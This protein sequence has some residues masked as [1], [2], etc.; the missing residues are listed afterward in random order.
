MD[1]E[2]NVF[3]LFNFY[4]HVWVLMSP[5]RAKIS[6]AE[7]ISVCRP[8]YGRVCIGRHRIVRGDSGED[9]EE[10]LPGVVAL[11]MAASRIKVHGCGECE[12]RGGE[13]SQCVGRRG[14]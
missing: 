6:P 7:P 1:R 11:R 10:D 5:R 3:Q 2:S 8:G 4:L 14:G 12:N 9:V 13:R